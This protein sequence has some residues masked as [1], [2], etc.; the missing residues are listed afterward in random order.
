MLCARII[1]FVLMR[2]Q[3]EARTIESSLFLNI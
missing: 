3:C 1:N 2:V